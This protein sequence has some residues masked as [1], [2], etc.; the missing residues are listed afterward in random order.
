MVGPIITPVATSVNFK[1]QSVAT[2][3]KVLA[4]CVFVVCVEE[5]PTRMQ[6][7]WKKGKQ[8]F[9]FKKRGSE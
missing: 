7:P 1:I 2:V 3:V 8:K 4:D 6:L 9:P 5:V